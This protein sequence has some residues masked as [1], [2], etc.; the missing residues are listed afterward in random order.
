MTI[1][2]VKY[3]PG[4]NMVSPGLEITYT[5]LLGRVNTMYVMITTSPV[6]LSR[7]DNQTVNPRNIPGQ[8][9]IQE[10]EA[11]EDRINQVFAEALEKYC[12]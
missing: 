8:L 12:K 6:R 1:N 2:E 3:V 4:I 7:K 11:N 10:F 5:D 9:M